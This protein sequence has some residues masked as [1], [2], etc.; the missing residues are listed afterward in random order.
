MIQIVKKYTYLNDIINSI[1]F[2][3]IMLRN[4]LEDPNLLKKISSFIFDNIGNLLSIRNISNTLKSNKTK[5]SQE[6]ITKYIEFLK[7]A[8]L[9]HEV[10]ACSMFLT[11]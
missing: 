2:K 11:V 8:F 7:E 9:I 3:D 4:K 10:Q 5:A 6:T 1:M